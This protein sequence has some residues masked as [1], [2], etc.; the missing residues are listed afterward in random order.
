L[1]PSLCLAMTGKL[2]RA[3][4]CKWRYTWSRDPQ[5]PSL[6]RYRPPALGHSQRPCR[7]ASPRALTAAL[8][9]R[10]PLGACWGLAK[11]PNGDSLCWHSRVQ[12]W[13]WQNLGPA[14]V[15]QR[16]RPSILALSKKTSLKQK[17]M[18]AYFTG[19]ARLPQRARLEGCSY[20]ADSLLSVKRRPGPAWGALGLPQGRG[21]RGVATSQD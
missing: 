4:L 3:A 20:S 14:W 13:R 6:G 10:Q 1:A 19:Y 12:A 8:S 7:F 17:L 9:F 5:S 16:Q 21:P 18:G 11:K 15:G 2:A